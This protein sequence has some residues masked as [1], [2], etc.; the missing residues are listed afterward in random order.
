[1]G[2]WN[3]GFKKIAEMMPTAFRSLPARPVLGI[4]PWSNN[5]PFIIPGGGTAILTQT[6]SNNFNTSD[7][8]T[9]SCTP[10]GFIPKVHVTLTL[11]T[12]HTFYVEDKGQVLNTGGV[13]KGSCPL[14]SNEGHAW[15]PLPLH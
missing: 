9:P 1:M 4:N 13:D 15:V 10:D 14:G 2:S 8:P 7:I 12:Q 3:S 6:S 5:T 11:G